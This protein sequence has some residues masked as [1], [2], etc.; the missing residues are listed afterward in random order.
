MGL[1]L[2]AREMDHHSLWPVLNQS[3]SGSTGI[4]SDHWR[5]ERALLHCAPMVCF[6]IHGAWA[7][8]A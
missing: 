4:G 7:R 3:S 8:R 6:G 2:N 5:S 1:R